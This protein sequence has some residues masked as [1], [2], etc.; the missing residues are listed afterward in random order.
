MI[1]SKMK[2]AD[3][4]GGERKRR[5]VRQI[6]LNSKVIVSDFFSD[7]SDRCWQSIENYQDLFYLLQTEPRYLA[8][9]VYLVS[10]DQVGCLFLRFLLMGRFR[11]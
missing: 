10:P 2:K 8:R 9:V 5:E 3:D 1:M 4:S 7:S 6:N 11:F